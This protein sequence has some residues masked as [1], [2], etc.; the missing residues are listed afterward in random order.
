MLGILRGGRG[1]CE[2]VITPEL[3]FPETY[4]DVPWEVCTVM[5]KPLEEYGESRYT[6]FGYTYDIDYMSAKEVAHML[7]DVVSKG[8][9]LALNL[10][11][12]PDGRLPGR[13]LRKL[14][15]LSEWMKIFSPAIH[16]TRAAAPYRAGRFAYTKSKDGK[17]IHAFYLYDEGETVA[18]EHAIPFEGKALSVTDMRS[19]KA[20]AFGQSGGVLTAQAPAEAVEALGD[21]ADCFV[22]EV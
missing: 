1:V 8:G 2:D 3:V 17:R 19:G 9:N 15:V 20:L 10:A 21:I 5:A 6:S 11:P 13:A 14:A 4:V 16:A 22:I 18:K 12:Q 7:L